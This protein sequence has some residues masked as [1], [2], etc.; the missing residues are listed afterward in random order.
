[1][2]NP[3]G[4]ELPPTV[5]LVS[6]IVGYQSA[7][8][9]FSS[10]SKSH[11]PKDKN[12]KIPPS[13]LPWI[14]TRRYL[15]LLNLGSSK[16]ELRKYIPRKDCCFAANSLAVFSAAIVALLSM[17]QPP[18][19]LSA[20]TAWNLLSMYRKVFNEKPL[21]TSAE[22]AKD[23]YFHP[24]PG[25]RRRSSLENFL[26]CVWKNFEVYIKLELSMRVLSGLSRILAE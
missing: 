1:M 17:E 7:G 8:Q 19:V 22:I 26:P 23:G 10:L 12:K 13:C 5:E 20:T 3:T 14:L 6:V 18:P 11:I 15:L 16:Q 4:Q 2:D 21:F 25:F 9:L 24:R